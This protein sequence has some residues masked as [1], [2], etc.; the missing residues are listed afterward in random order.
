LKDGGCKVEVSDGLG[1]G[2]RLSVGEGLGSS[3]GSVTVGDGLGI[4]TVKLV[5][6]K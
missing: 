3:V 4:F 5:D 6:N 2:V 1:V